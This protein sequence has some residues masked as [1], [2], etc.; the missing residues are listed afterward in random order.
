MFFNK[1]SILNHYPSFNLQTNKIFS[2]IRVVLVGTTHPGNIGAS[3]RAMKNMGL[4]N[5]FLVNPKEF[6]AP[7]ATWRAA[8]AA[9]ILD[10]AIVVETIDQAIEGCS[11]IIG[12]S[13]RDRRIPWPTLDARDCGNRVVN[14]ARSHKVA[15][16]FGREDRGLSNEELQKCTYH[17]NI[18]TDSEYSSLNLAMAVQL[19]CYEIRMAFL[20]NSKDNLTWDQP[21]ATADQLESFYDHLFSTLVT[22]KFYDPENPK[23]LITRLKRLFSRVRLDQ[24]E[25][26]ILRGLL[27]SIERNP[28]DD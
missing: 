28:K 3:A 18:P 6:P 9:D 14:E 13:A 27:S 16:L 15:I 23:Q 24:M 17:M 4:N 10:N 19:L 22:L 12:T 25:V 21:L 7:R 20:E 5:L 26:S 2:N 11:L 8:N 1:S